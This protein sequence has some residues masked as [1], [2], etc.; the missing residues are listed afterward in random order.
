MVWMC[1]PGHCAVMHGRPHAVIGFIISQAP[2]IILQAVGLWDKALHARDLQSTAHTPYLGLGRV[3]VQLRPAV[4]AVG[5]V[6]RPVAI[7]GPK[8]KEFFIC[9][10]SLMVKSEKKLRFYQCI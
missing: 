9:K 2:L 6:K 5:G 7:H 1:Q 8:E 4:C 10:S 3:R